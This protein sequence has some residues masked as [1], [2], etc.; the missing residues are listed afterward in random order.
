METIIFFFVSLHSEW[1]YFG[2]FLAIFMQKGTNCV[3]L[4]LN[5]SRLGHLKIH[6][7]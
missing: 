2:G 7:I 5:S 1:P 6:V 3:N 4:N